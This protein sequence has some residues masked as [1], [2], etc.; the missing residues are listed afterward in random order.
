MNQ[1]IEDPAV[2]CRE[3]ARCCGSRIFL[4]PWFF[5]EAIILMLSE[6]KH[7]AFSQNR[8]QQV[9][10]ET[11][12]PRFFKDIPCQ[13]PVVCIDDPRIFPGGAQ[14]TFEPPIRGVKAVCIMDIMTTKTGI[15]QTA[16]E[17]V[18]PIDSN[19]AVFGG[20]IFP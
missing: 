4:P 14:Q 2:S 12:D 18:F 20:S 7:Q 1:Q 16:D 11:D 15:P 13:E 10:K 19:M 8:I 17:F 6:V 9:I 5:P 3:C